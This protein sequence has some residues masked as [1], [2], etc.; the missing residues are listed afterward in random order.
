MRTCIVLCEVL[1]QSR[2]VKFLDEISNIF[3]IVVY[4]ALKCENILIKGKGLEAFGIFCL[5]KAGNFHDF[6]EILQ[7]TLKEF[8]TGYVEMIALTFVI[9]FLMIYD[10]EK[11]SSS[12]DDLINI[13]TSYKKVKNQHFQ[14]VSIQGLCKLFTIG[15]L[16]RIDIL[17]DLL[18]QY[19]LS[20]PT[21]QI[22]QYLHIFLLNY[23]RFSLKNSKILANSYFLTV[24]RVKTEFH[25][26]IDK[27]AS[28]HS[29][30]LASLDP[31]KQNFSHSSE[32]LHFYLFFILSQ[33]LLTKA[34]SNHLI[35]RLVL[36]V[37]FCTFNYSEAKIAS[38]ILQDLKNSAS[39][40][41]VRSALEKIDE[42]LKNSQN[43]L[44]LKEMRG[45][46]EN[47]RQLFDDLRK[48]F[49]NLEVLGKIYT[50]E[51]GENSVKK[52]Q[53]Y[54]NENKENEENNEK[55]EG[56]QSFPSKRQRLS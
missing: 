7:K 43:S 17:S 8:A 44:E 2:V 13:L 11:A 51:L 32:N 56:F 14:L 37:K 9:D 1:R 12:Q 19:F 23:S 36:Q 52:K 46:E 42:Q 34:H 4:P 5:K 49:E 20:N 6:L 26:D 33:K 25:S 47:E 15:R 16:E 29:F 31:E 18:F 10:F 41:T 24:S 27:L 38:F 55:N 53:K 48:N 3:D 28:I 22:K 45:L 30:I 21:D 40:K 35:S 54:R 50:D 39:D